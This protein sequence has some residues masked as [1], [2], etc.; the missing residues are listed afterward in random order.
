MKNAK[1]KVRGP[2]RRLGF[3]SVSV[4][5]SDWGVKTAR[6]EKPRGA[7]GSGLTPFRTC[8]PVTP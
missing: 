2:L 7:T 3:R 8:L 1:E 4:A 6:H 5:A